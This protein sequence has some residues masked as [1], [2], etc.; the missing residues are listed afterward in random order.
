MDAQPFAETQQ[1]FVKQRCAPRSCYG[2]LRV[3]VPRASTPR[4][5]HHC[6]DE[7]PAN[8]TACLAIGICATN[9]AR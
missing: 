9:R 6:P 2:L 7:W 8:L 3:S 4:R 1:F 5:T